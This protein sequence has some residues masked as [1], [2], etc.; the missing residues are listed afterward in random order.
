MSIKKSTASL[1][2]VE[3]N[4]VLSQE[5]THYLTE[6]GFD[7]RHADGG[8]A[9]NEAL[10]ERH[11]DILILDLNMAGEDGLSISQRSR[12][13]L[14][15]G[16]ILMLTARVMSYDKLAGYESGADVYMTKPAKPAELSA[17]IRNLWK[18]LAPQH[19]QPKWIL[20]T[21]QLNIRHHQATT[22]ALTSVEA[23]LLKALALGNGCV[24][25][26][27]LHFVLEDQNIEFIKFKL[28]LEV[29]ISRLRVKLSPFTGQVNPI[30]AVRGRGYQLCIELE[31]LY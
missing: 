8:Q 20:D 13:T 16:G 11:A 23:D 17:A 2:L 24:E 6:E 21:K 27:T 1:I 22:V 26:E 3:D 29:L 18:R 30:K 4:E 10:L 31:I 9:L 28:R 15:A 7:V 25:T 14:P 5:L 19:S 12:K